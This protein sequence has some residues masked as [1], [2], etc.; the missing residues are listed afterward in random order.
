[1][2]QNF[3][4]GEILAIIILALV[5]LGPDRLPEMAR[6][7]GKLIHKL[8]TMAN[9]LQGQVQGVMDDPA[10]QPL[11]E[12][13]EFAARPRQ[14]LA[15]Y[16]LEAEA[17]ERARAEQTSMEAAGA[18][19]TADGGA[20]DVGAAAGTETTAE[21]EPAADAPASSSVQERESA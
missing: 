18:D 16:A 10:M 20:A 2:I 19:T 21:A 17:E 13:G 6:N 11:R 7:A 1:M 14:K 15:E 5:L 3:G 8:K 9:G 4:G 12:L